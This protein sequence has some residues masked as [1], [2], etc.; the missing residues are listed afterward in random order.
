MQQT[1]G[2]KI[3]R[4]DFSEPQGGKGPCDRKAATIKAHIRRFVDEGHDVIT[5]DDLLRCHLVQ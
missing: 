4:V 5:A 1:T 2:I 3:G